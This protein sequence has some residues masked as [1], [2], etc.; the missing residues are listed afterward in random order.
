LTEPSLAERSL[1]PRN[2]SY[3][4]WQ[5]ASPSRRVV[6][7]DLLVCARDGRG[8]R[9]LQAHRDGLWV[10]T[11]K[12]GIG[13]SFSPLLQAHRDGLWVSTRVTFRV[14]FVIDR[15]Q[16]HR[17]G[18]WVSTDRAAGRTA[19]AV[20]VASPSRRVVGLD[21]ARIIGRHRQIRLQAHRDGLW[22]STRHRSSVTPRVRT[23][24]WAMGVASPSRRVV[25][26]D[27]AI[28]GC[29]RR[30]CVVASPSRRVVGLDLAWR[31]QPF[32]TSSSCKPIETACGSRHDP[33]G[34]FASR[35][36]GFVFLGIREPGRLGNQ[37]LAVDLEACDHEPR[38]TVLLGDLAPW[39]LWWSVDESDAAIAAVRTAGC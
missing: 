34:G 17:D 28:G 36:V 14:A 19:A 21:M 20:H 1:C 30:A 18:L 15:L 13:P 11:R 22:V 32:L 25:G 39:A 12:L 37:K 27:G 5:V 26:L 35:C 24:P 16:A 23:A 31:G 7:L 33:G 10:S 2:S 38:R 6:G 3:C 9:R 4:S 8:R 29:A